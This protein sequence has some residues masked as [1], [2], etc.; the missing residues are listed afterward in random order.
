M[1]FRVK[2]RFIAG[3]VCPKCHAVDSILWLQE[4]EEII[5]C[6]HCDYMQ[7]KS[8]IDPA[9]VTKAKASEQVIHW[10]K[11]SDTKNS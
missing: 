3:A 10:H 4:P 11:P 8:D 5:Q 7:K 6:I 9:P 1:S 2:K